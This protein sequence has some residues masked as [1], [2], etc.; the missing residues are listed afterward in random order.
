MKSINEEYLKQKRLKVE[1]L[2]RGL[3]WL[4][5]GTHADLIEAANFIKT[6]ENRQGMQVSCPEEIAF[7]KKWIDKEKLLEIIK[8][9]LKTDYGKYLRDLAEG[10]IF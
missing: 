5:T 3:A 2:G 6:I 4:D 1:R 8:T 9:F 7:R 10:K